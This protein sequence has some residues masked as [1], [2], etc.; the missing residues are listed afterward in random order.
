MS[1]QLDRVLQIILMIPQEPH[2]ISR[3]KIQKKLE[4]QRYTVND[5]MIQR[6][7]EKLIDVF[8]GNLICKSCKE[9]FETLTY[10]ANDDKT[11]RYFWR[12]EYKDLKLVG[13]NINQALSLQLINT[14]LT[15]LLPKTTLEDLEP[16]FAEATNV[17]DHHE[18][19]PLTKWPH[20]I[21]IVEPSQPLIFPEINPDVQM[22]VSE[23]LLKERQVIIQYRRNDSV[24]N[25]Y[26]L[27]PIGLVLRNGTHYLIATKVIN[28]ERRQFALHR[29]LAIDV[30]NEACE[31]QEYTLEDCLRDGQ[32]GFNMTGT[33]PYGMIGFKG[34][35]DGILA[36]HLSESRLSEDQK[37]EHIGNNHYEISAT[38]KETEQLY[39]WLLSF[40]SR[41]EV[42][43]PKHL[44][45]KMA[46]TVS[47]MQ[48]R[49]EPKN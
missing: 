5:R 27:N 46:I 15:T 26:R 17:L 23:A 11:H 47:E 41:V 10:F 4:N 32:M 25:E 49:Y 40:G 30:L 39:W 38:I 34:I 37:I 16:L 3:S 42:L 35:F 6:D 9:Y 20:K 29:I 43:E 48:S 13:L 7:M 22:S 33:A 21:A 28:H 31:P 12:K 1:I 45:E 24:C 36:N 14:Y 8:Q 19:N 44:R 18:N 2:A